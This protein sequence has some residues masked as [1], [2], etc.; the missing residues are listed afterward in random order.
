MFLFFMCLSLV[1]VFFTFMFVFLIILFF[2]FAFFIH[3]CMFFCCYCSLPSSPRTRKVLGMFPHLFQKARHDVS[4]NMLHHKLETMYPQTG[5]HRLHQLLKEIKKSDQMLAQRE[6]MLQF[7]DE[8]NHLLQ[9]D[10]K[11]HK[12][13]RWD[14]PGSLQAVLAD[15]KPLP[16]GITM[17]VVD[18]IW[19]FASF[20]KN[21]VYSNNEVVRLAIGRFANEIVQQ[22]QTKIDASRKGARAPKQHPYTMMLYLGHDSTVI[23]LLHLLKNFSMG[24]PWP[25]FGSTILFELYKSKCEAHYFLT[26]PCPDEALE[27]DYY[28]RI[29]YNGKVLRLPTV[30]ADYIPFD[31]LREHV[32]PYVPVDYAAECIPK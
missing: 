10:P 4:I 9:I 17:D 8:M 5:C 23:P 18:K 31:K 19:E 7:S 21:L 3:T 29:I 1:I 30:A 26:S 24:D 22:M 14:K 27:D 25:T 13:F 12:A 16:R 11:E 2:S 20:K 15:Q 28:V 32:T 6:K